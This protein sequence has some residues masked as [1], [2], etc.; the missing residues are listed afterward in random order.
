[1][2]EVPKKKLTF[3]KGERF[4]KKTL[5]KNQTNESK[6]SENEK[7]SVLYTIYDRYRNFCRQANLSGAESEF[8]EKY[9]DLGFAY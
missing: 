7:K 6:K 3:Q 1:M 9:L 8:E 2:I 5:P 4:M